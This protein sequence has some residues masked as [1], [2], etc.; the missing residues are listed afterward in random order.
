[1]KIPIFT[2][3]VTVLCFE[4]AACADD[5]T[6]VGGLGSGEHF[7]YE[8]TR[9]HGKEQLVTKLEKAGAVYE[10]VR[11]SKEEFQIRQAGDT[12]DVFFKFNTELNDGGVILMNGKLVDLLKTQDKVAALMYGDS[13]YFLIEA[14]QEIPELKK[15]QIYI[16]SKPIRAQNWHR[17]F[18]ARSR[19]YYHGADEVRYPLSDKVASAKLLDSRKIEFIY[20]DLHGKA[21]NAD[22]C[23]YKDATLFKNNKEVVKEAIVTDY[24]SD[25]KSWLSGLERM[26]QDKDVRAI[27]T[28]YYDKHELI[29]AFS[30]ASSPEIHKKLIELVEQVYASPKK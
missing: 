29:S 9:W 11:V 22:V 14:S 27:R 28:K 2:L 23:F 18:M 17:T 24:I 8:L 25:D 10:F 21:G 1:M 7:P 5:H 12:P 4:Y 19:D 3:L 13:G 6:S 16:I 26:L 20:K 30:N 15:G